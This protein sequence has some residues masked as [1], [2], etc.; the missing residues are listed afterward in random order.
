METAVDRRFALGVVIALLVVSCS[1][2]DVPAPVVREQFDFAE[3][4][5]TVAGASL[6][7]VS[8]GYRPR[9]LN[10]VW[11]LSLRCQDAEGCRGR[12]RATITYAGGGWTNHVVLSGVIDAVDQGVAV[13]SRSE[14]GT[15]PVAEVLAVDV[16]IEALAAR[17]SRP[18][19]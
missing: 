15:I 11:E 3:F 4:D 14:R 19:E 13:V 2:Q 10:T 6:E 9:D 17:R 12:V 5:A 18:R 7:V 1:G 8:V 16:R